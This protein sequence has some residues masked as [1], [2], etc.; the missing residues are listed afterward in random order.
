MGT[1]PP[2]AHSHAAYVL[3]TRMMKHPTAV[4][5]FLGDLEDKLRPGAGKGAA[6]VRVPT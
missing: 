6:R 5:A 3:E 4:L 1:S 2:C